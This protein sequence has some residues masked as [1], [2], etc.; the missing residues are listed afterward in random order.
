MTICPNPT[1]FGGTNAIGGAP[2]YF[3]FG[4]NKGNTAMNRYYNKYIG[5]NILN[6]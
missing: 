1:F 2:W 5:E 4:L 3:Y 6:E